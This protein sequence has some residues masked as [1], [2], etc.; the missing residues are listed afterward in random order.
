MRI[1]PRQLRELQRL[2]ADRIAP[3]GSVVNECQPDTAARVAR[4]PS[5]SRRI[6]EVDAARPIMYTSP[7]HYETFCEC[8]D[9]PSKWPEDMEW[10]KMQDINERFY[11]QPY[12]FETDGF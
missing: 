12:N 2:M 10:C 9:W 6:L 5:N 8:K 4:D 3:Q 11:S 1:H 7:A